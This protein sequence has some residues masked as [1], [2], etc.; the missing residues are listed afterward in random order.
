ML[1]RK[2]Q[3]DE[4]AEGRGQRWERA[5]FMVFEKSSMAHS[6]IGP[7][8]GRLHSWLLCSQSECTA[9]VKHFDKANIR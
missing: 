1:E 7:P 8:G 4:G 3:E 5:V 9:D 2:T 6:L